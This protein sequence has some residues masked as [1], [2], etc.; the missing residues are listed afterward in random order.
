[1]CNRECRCGSWLGA[2]PRPRPCCETCGPR[3]PCQGCTRHYGR[4]RIGSTSCSIWLIAGW[5]RRARAAW[6]PRRCS[7]G[8]GRLP[9]SLRP[10]GL[11]DSCMVIF[12]RPTCCPVR[13]PAW[14]RSIPGR[15][16]AT[17]T[18][19]LWTGYLKELQIQPCWSRGPR[20]WPRWFL[21][22]LHVVHWIG[23]GPRPPSSRSHACVQGGTTRRPGSSWPW[24]AADP[25][26]GHEW[27]SGGVGREAGEGARGPGAQGG[28]A[29]VGAVAG[30]QVEDEAAAPDAFAGRGEGLV[31]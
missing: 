17:R 7:A 30:Q 5:R 19:T 6:W 25:G 8:R 23:A 9:W 31:P 12:I 15:R 27:S 16:G 3:L 29:S 13:A 4:S 2:C 22:S 11:W 24:A 28:H 21:A 14:W 1:M 10:A 18:T 20:S 26:G